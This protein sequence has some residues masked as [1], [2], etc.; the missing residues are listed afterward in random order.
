MCRTDRQTDRVTSWAPVGAK[1][2]VTAFLGAHS[3]IKKEDADGHIDRELL[4]NNENENKV[5][6][7]MKDL[8][9][10]IPVIEQRGKVAIAFTKLSDE[11]EEIKAFECNLDVQIIRFKVFEC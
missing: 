7:S 2:E 9:D 1:K 4:K 8:K 11:L 3:F 6:Q 5:L 10:L